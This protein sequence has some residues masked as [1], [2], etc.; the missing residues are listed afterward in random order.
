[1]QLR[2]YKL[3]GWGTR[4][5]E[6]KRIFGHKEMPQNSKNSYWGEGKE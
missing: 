1:M 6:E 5:G 3:W 4:W 2:E